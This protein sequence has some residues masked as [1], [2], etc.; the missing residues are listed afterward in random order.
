MHLNVITVGMAWWHLIR[1][2]GKQLI[3]ESAYV[4]KQEACK[5]LNYDVIAWWRQQME[6]FSV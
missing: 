2:P 3:E 5:W 6:T 1:A 4:Y